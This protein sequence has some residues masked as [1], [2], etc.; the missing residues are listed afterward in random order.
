MYKEFQDNI[1]EEI[2][3]LSDLENKEFLNGKTFSIYII[4]I[5]H[6]HSKKKERKKEKH[7][8]KQMKKY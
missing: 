2:I 8:T 7:I 6:S 3:V 1:N 4:I 5:I